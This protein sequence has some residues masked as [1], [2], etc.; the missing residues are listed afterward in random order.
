MAQAT[1]P[2]GAVDEPAISLPASSSTAGILANDADRD[3]TYHLKWIHW[4]TDRIPIIMQSKNG[5]CPLIAIMNVL[6]LRE[7]I[8]LPS[9]LEQI[10][11]DQLLSY[12]GECLMDCVTSTA[13]LSESDPKP[14]C[15]QPSPRDPPAESEQPSSSDPNIETSAQ[16]KSNEEVATESCSS[17]KESTQSPTPSTSR[18]R[19]NEC[20]TSL[21]DDLRLNLEQNIHDAMEIMPKFKTGLDVNIKFS[22][23]SNFEFTPEC[24]IFDLL[25]IP[26]YHGWLIDADLSDL[27]SAIGHLS[28]NQVVDM[29]ITHKNSTDPTTQTNVLLAE[30]FLDRTASQLTLFGLNELRSKIRDNEIGILFRNNHFL[31][32]FKRDGQLYT[33]VTDHGYLTEENVIWESLDS[34]EGAGRYFNSEFQDAG[35][36]ERQISEFRAIDERRRQLENDFLMALSLKEEEEEAVAAAVAAS[37][38]GT[39]C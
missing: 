31:T 3:S 8:K 32:L 4:N 35:T 19:S 9:M 1:T 22:G 16:T 39:N 10:T 15:T 36:A 23:I 25:R 5:P 18:S 14:S 38:D 2:V 30:D 11:A 34:I 13:P 26:L 21:N 20:A 29:I 7:K 12:L 17:Y 33:L 28:Y 37:S 24:I 6:L 27:K